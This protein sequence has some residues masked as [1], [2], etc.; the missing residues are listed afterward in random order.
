MRFAPYAPL[1]IA[2]L[3]ISLPNASIAQTSQS[4]RRQRLI[5]EVAQAP[6]FEAGS[7]SAGKHGPFIAMANFA[8]YQ[9]TQDQ[10]ALDKA[11]RIAAQA[12]DGGG[13]MF[14][15]HNLAA[16]YM[17]YKD[18]FTPDLRE[19]YRDALVNYGYVDFEDRRPGGATENHRLM[20]ACA[21][22]LA[23]QEWPEFDDEKYEICR[24]WLLD[25]F[26]KRVARGYW[27]YHSP[28]YFIHHTGPML[29]L[30]EH[31]DPEVE[32]RRAE[33]LELQRRATLMLE[34]MFAGLVSQWNQGVWITSNG[35]NYHPPL[36][37]IAAAAEQESYAL[38]WMYLGGCPA[39]PFAKPLDHSYFSTAQF[40]V[41]RY[42]LPAIFHR[43]AHDREQPYTHREHFLPGP[44]A[45]KTS[46]IH[47]HYGLFSQRDSTEEGRSAFNQVHRWSLTW[48][49]D[50]PQP[51]TL[52]L[53]HPY[54]DYAANPNDDAYA[55]GATNAEQVLQ[56]QGTLIAVY[57]IQDGNPWIEGPLPRKAV[58]AQ[59]QQ[60]GWLFLHT[61][62]MLAALWCANG[63]TMPQG[64]YAGYDG[65]ARLRSDGAQ[66]ALAL[67]TAPASQFGNDAPQAALE[68]FAQ[69]ILD[70]C[71]MDYQTDAQQ[72]PQLRFTNLNG[73]VLE[74]AFNG[75]RRINGREVVFDA[76]WPLLQSP[77]M[78]HDFRGNTLTLKHEGQTRRYDWNTWTVDE[79]GNP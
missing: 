48:I 66:N 4:E 43:I 16:L 1:F 28:T 26:N 58:I 65:L 20:Y 9:Q 30:I 37:S 19:A 75:P 64:N 42:D 25:Q 23:E 24:E 57:N 70:S 18:L 29:S 55:R 13:A 11:R 5:H 17:Q 39:P 7:Q 44:N 3:L 21:A 78:Q 67:E 33:R 12:M 8:R 35:R 68:R 61:G 45:F 73:D 41:A 56:L 47:P 38:L 22:I 60:D 15:I 59:M 46:Y 51:A 52:F 2:L 32:H 14:R 6:A 62:K 10:A 36:N 77:F 63:L 34:W 31:I 76:N 74:I 54:P 69:S 53:K 79:S 71:T 49:T 72:R 40:A 27:E 50:P